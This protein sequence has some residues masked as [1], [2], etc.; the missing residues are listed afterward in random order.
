MVGAN[1]ILTVSYGTFSCTLEGFDEPFSTMKSIAEYFR[2]LAADDRYFGAEPPTPDAEMLHKIAEREIHRRVESKIHANGIVL[3]PQGAQ[4][5]LSGAMDDGPSRPNTSRDITVTGASDE[6]LVARGIPARAAA[7]QAAS[8]AVENPAPLDDALDDIAEPATAALAQ[9]VLSGAQAGEQVTETVAAKLQRIRTAVAEARAREISAPAFTEDQHAA[10][11]Y[12]ENSQDVVAGESD[13]EFDLDISG[14]IEQEEDALDVSACEAIEQAATVAAPAE[15]IADQ[16]D[17]EQDESPVDA[18]L[19]ELEEEHQSESF[20]DE[21]Q[22]PFAEDTSEDVTTE[23]DEEAKARAE[24]RALRRAARA[25]AAEHARAEAENAE[26]AAQADAESQAEHVEQIAQDGE[27]ALALEADL[28]DASETE[29][30]TAPR[31]RARVIKVRRADAE[32]A[33]EFSDTSEDT[34]TPAATDDPT[35]ASIKAVLA[36]AGSRSVAAEP[37]KP[38][39]S[40]TTAPEEDPQDDDDALLAMIGAQI[41]ETPLQPASH[42]A[43]KSNLTVED[44]DDLAAELAELERDWD[45]KGQDDRSDSTI[46]ADISETLRANSTQE[47]APLT[48]VVQPLTHDENGEVDVSRLMREANTKLEGAET[49][50]RFSAIAHLKAAVAATVAD[51]K[52][53][54]TEGK[55]ENDDIDTS[56]PYRDDLTR[57]VRPRR[58]AIA[59]TA[60]PRPT[61]A[62]AKAAPLV[63]V[64]EQRV[65]ETPARVAEPVRPRRVSAADLNARAEAD[66][67]VARSDETIDRAPAEAIDFADFADRLG[68]TG[69]ADLLE[70]AAA[71]SEGVEGR[72]HFSRPQIIRK[73]AALTGQARYDREAGLR[74]FGTLLREGK[75]AKVKRG[76]FAI[77]EQSRFYKE[78]RRAGA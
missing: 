38:A 3:R 21:P 57:A 75:I 72:P 55:S 47:A 39:P 67:E 11:Y 14:P 48:P 32:E 33:A 54:A 10:P 53:R 9:S 7:V 19:E 74:S 28:E 8:V 40:T 44:E 31:L 25:R 27:D 64:S 29:E 23:F 6:E 68:A 20:N 69:L 61:V 77:T 15:E 17:A 56:E 41:N 24:R 35:E 22:A 1:K 4:D 13:F 26:R 36:A 73:V 45:H 62:P 58:P 37:V 59:E 51:R 65:D 76:Q 46:D 16:V 2:D 12:D 71:F 52:F 60:T 66:F 30:L 34:D 50:R 70:A 18:P 78:A 43:P 49:R 42:L 5:T 63:L